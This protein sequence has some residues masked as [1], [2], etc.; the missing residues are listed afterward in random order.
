MVE[1]SFKPRQFSS[2]PHVLNPK[3]HYL[4]II[5]QVIMQW[6]SNIYGKPLAFWIKKSFELIQGGV[7]LS[8][9]VLRGLGGCHSYCIHALLPQ[10]LF[11]S[12]N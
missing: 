5:K 9:S 11:L 10:Y 4:S 12:K 7:R 3:F 6:H 1:L 8:P 2:G